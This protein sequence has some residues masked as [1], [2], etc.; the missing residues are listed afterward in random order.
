MQVKVDNKVI[1]EITQT[2]VDLLAYDLLDVQAEI[3]RRL[4][5]IIEHKVGECYKRFKEEW[6]KKL[7]KDS[8]VNF[9]PSKRDE[10][11]AFVKARSDYKNRSQREK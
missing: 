4:K 2:D 8:S 5:Y 3:E 1:F 7:E 10:Y 6:D 11:V 9:I